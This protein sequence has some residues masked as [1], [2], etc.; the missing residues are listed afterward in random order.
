MF[1]QWTEHLSALIRDQKDLKHQFLREIARD[2]AV[3]PS[4]SDAIIRARLA[5]YRL[6][7]LRWAIETIAA[8]AR[9]SHAELM[10]VLVPSADDP[11]VLI[12]QFTGARRLFAQLGVPTLDI[13]DTFAYLEDMAEVRVNFADRHPNARGHQML[14]ARLAEALERSPAA[15]RVLLG[16]EW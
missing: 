2:A 8:H 16:R 13:L 11:E 14:F 3:T 10:I 6:R 7:T 12:D 4:M 5:P 1:R 15:S 9:Q